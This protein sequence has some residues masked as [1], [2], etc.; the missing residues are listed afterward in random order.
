MTRFALALCLF[1]AACSGERP[2]EITDARVQLPVI[3]GR[4]GAAYFTVSGGAPGTR[5]VSVSSPAFKRIELHDSM[6]NGMRRLDAV[7]VGERLSFAPG[8]RHAMLFGIAP[9]AKASD[10]IPLVF[11]F[12]PGG[13]VEVAAAVTAVGN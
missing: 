7:S 11:R 3:A 6:A 8:G 13:S 9:G 4:P 10:R 1:A 5:L 2:I 12:E